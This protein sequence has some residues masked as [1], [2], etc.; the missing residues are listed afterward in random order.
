[1]NQE[2]HI[3]YPV[4]WEEEYCRIGFVTL[5]RRSYP[6]MF[7]DYSGAGVLGTKDLFAQY[8]LM[9]LLRH[10]HDI[11]S[12]TWYKLCCDVVRSKEKA[13]VLRRWKIM[14]EYMGEPSFT[15]LQTALK[16]NGFHNFRGEPDLFCWKEDSREWFFAEAKTKDKVLP[17]QR[18][19]FSICQSVLGS[20]ADIRVYS[21]VRSSN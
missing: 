3:S 21:L 10:D 13:L 18:K 11:Q 5:W 15:R 14:S 19:W 9:Y 7:A 17:S 12:L 16:E 2:F 8:A 1:M 20:N 6:D 4:E